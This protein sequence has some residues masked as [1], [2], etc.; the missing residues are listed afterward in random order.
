MVKNNMMENSPKILFVSPYIPYPKAGVKEDNLDYF[1]YR[2]TFGQG[3]F[4]IRQMHSWHPLH[5]LAQNLPVFSV[6]LENPEF[7][8]FTSEIEIGNYD[9]VAITFTV[10]LSDRVLYMSRWLKNNFPDIEIII[11]GYG[12]SIFSEQ[13]GIEQE[14]AKYVDHVCT[15]E[16]LLFMMDYLKKNWKIDTEIPYSQ[17]LIPAENSVFRTHIPLFRQLNFVA[18]LGCSHGCEF[19]ATSSHFDRKKIKILEGKSLYQIIRKQADKYPKINSAIIYD[20]NFLDNR[21]EVL[22]FMKCMEN[23]MD[24]Q[25]RPFLITVF[26]S[27]HSIMKYEIEELIRCGIGTIFVGVESFDDEILNRMHKRGGGDVNELFEKLHRHGINTLGSMVIGWDEHDHVNI[28]KELDLFIDLTPTFYQIVPLHP[29]PGTPLWKRMKSKKR[30]IP[31]YKYEE[32]GVYRN[33]FKYKNFTQCEIQKHVFSAY[34]KL[35]NVDG[36]WPFRLFS[37]LLNGYSNLKDSESEIL[38]LRAKGYKKMLS[39]VGPL[40]CISGLVFK[41]EFREKWKKMIKLYFYEMPVIALLS[42]LSGLFLLPALAVIYILTKIK[43]YIMPH[44]DQPDTRRIIYDNSEP[45]RD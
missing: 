33:S 43:F 16:G 13:L 7:E 9:I 41:G 17:E 23:D 6:V 21:I 38:Q 26:S 20:E 2:N 25:T 44:G 24:F 31:D 11:G 15:G 29:L 39:Q 42:L 36:P 27:L 40:A 14:I 18:S 30:I 5:Y 4:Q 34:D 45:G 1:Y 8:Q 10:M 32:D 3:L 28:K 37:N 12:T 19:C 35:V 22:K